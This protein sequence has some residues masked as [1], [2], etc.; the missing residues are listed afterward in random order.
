MGNGVSVVTPAFNGGVVLAVDAP[1]IKVAPNTSAKSAKSN[2]LFDI[3]F[4]H[5][6]G[7]SLL[8]FT[9][10]RTAPSLVAMP[11]RTT[12]SKFYLCAAAQTR[13]L[14][15]TTKLLAKSTAAT[16]A[17]IMRVHFA[18]ALNFPSRVAKMLSTNT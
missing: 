17:Q 2:F 18:G 6:P 9:A 15:A 8:I 5:D 1:L 13:Q 10:R 14:A 11:I 3:K 4:I 12:H 16:G 7:F